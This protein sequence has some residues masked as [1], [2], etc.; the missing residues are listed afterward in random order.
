MNRFKQVL[1]NPKRLFKLAVALAVVLLGIHGVSLWAGGGQVIDAETGKP[2]AGVFVMA[3]FNATG[4]T[5]VSQTTVCHSF[6]ITQTD[7]DGLYRLPTFSWN[8]FPFFAN[9]HRLVDVYM[10]DYET[11]PNDILAE[12]VIKMRRRTGTVQQ[13]LD[14][15]VRGTRYGQ[16]VSEGETREKL[17]PLY[18]AQFEEARNI[19]ESPS[20]KKIVQSLRL[21][22]VEAEMGHEAFM[23][24]YINE[25]Q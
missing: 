1:Q 4:Y 25:R 19:A 14:W 12:A 21:S 15:L 13:R 5:P 8:F 24:M 3:R 17:A 11:F 20:E 9:R 6:A 7:K 23:K 2:L 18:K 22:Y 10:A 16:C